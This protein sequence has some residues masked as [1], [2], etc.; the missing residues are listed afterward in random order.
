MVL[1][2]VS[3]EV[4]LSRL[5]AQFFQV[6]LIAVG[7]SLSSVFG[8]ERQDV[9]LGLERLGQGFEQL[10]GLERHVG[11]G[12]RH[13]TD[14]ERVLGAG[15]AVESALVHALQ[16]RRRAEEGTPRIVIFLAPLA[17]KRPGVGG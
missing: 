8:P 13:G 4:S 15:L 16:D 2:S 6:V 10:L 14:L 11:E 9:G 1:V 17:A 12:A 3:F 5:S 7:S